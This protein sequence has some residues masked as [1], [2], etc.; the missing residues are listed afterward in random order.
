MSYDMSIGNEEF[1]YTYNVAPMWY[2]AIPDAGIRAHYGLTGRDAVPRLRHI[3][4]YME[5]HRDELLEMEP[6]NGWG[7]YDGALGFV[8]RLIAASLRH[9]DDVWYGD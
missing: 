7:S 3:R 8:N 4:E 6:E 5:D 1:N 9:P 2:A